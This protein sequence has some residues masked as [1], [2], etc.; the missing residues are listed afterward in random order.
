VLTKSMFFF[1]SASLTNPASPACGAAGSPL[2]SGFLGK[3]RAHS[4]AIRLSPTPLRNGRLQAS[5]M[6]GWQAVSAK[7]VNVLGH[8]ELVACP[9]PLVADRNHHLPHQEHSVRHRSEHESARPVEGLDRLVGAPEVRWGMATVRVAE[10]SGRRVD[11]AVEH[12]D[13]QIHRI[14]RAQRSVSEASA[15]IGEITRPSSRVQLK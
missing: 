6:S 3:T 13:E 9:D 15:G 2:T 4:L 1:S 8:P 14:L 7:A 11:Y 5:C 10:H 12:R